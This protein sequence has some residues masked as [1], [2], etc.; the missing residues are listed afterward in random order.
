MTKVFQKS[1]QRIKFLAYLITIAG[2]VPFYI[3]LVLFIIVQVHPF[4]SFCVIV[5]SGLIITFV[6]GSN[7]IIILSASNFKKINLTYYLFFIINSIIPI[8][9]SCYIIVEESFNGN[10]F[11]Y[12]YLGTILILLLFFDLIFYLNK[13]IE[14]WW[15]KLRFFGSISSGISLI[16]INIINL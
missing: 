6:C 9:L 12:I 4:Y 7:W 10:S 3:A 13:I 11:S 14:L 15:L 2:A 5:Y 1:D 16:I 8:L